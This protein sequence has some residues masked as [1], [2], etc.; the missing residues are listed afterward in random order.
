VPETVQAEISWRLL[1]CHYAGE[2]GYMKPELWSSFRKYFDGNVLLFE[3]IREQFDEWRE[4]FRTRQ[5]PEKTILRILNLRTPL[6]FEAAAYL[7]EPVG[8]QAAHQIGEWLVREL[9]RACHQISFVSPNLRDYSLVI[10]F[11]PT[12]PVEYRKIEAY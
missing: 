6:I 4:N 5:S 11:L 9:Q 8:Q 10:Q 2:Q 12:S 7:L 1:V 3:Q